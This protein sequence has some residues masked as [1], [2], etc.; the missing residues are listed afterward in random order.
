MTETLFVCPL[1]LQISL[2][3][4]LIDNSPE[5]FGLDVVALWYE[6]SFYNPPGANTSSDHMTPSSETE[7]EVSSCSRARTY[8]PGHDEATIIP[9][10]PP[11]YEGIIGVYT[12]S[13]TI[14]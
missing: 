1:L 2:I 10:A 4:F 7:H 14:R 3:T 11:L 8:T 12:C 13:T 6:T 5:L 9:V